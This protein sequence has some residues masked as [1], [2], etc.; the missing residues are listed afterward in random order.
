MIPYRI[1]D[2]DNTV[3]YHW[4]L[5]FIIAY[6]VLA[7]FAFA[8]RHPMCD[9]SRLGSICVLDIF[10][11]GSGSELISFGCALSLGQL[12]PVWSC[13]GGLG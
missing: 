10:A 9:G 2:Y 4:L 6:V 13:H 7:F 1:T 8:L 5:H 12:Q 11:D 3:Q